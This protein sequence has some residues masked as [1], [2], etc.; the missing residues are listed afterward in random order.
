[1]GNDMTVSGAQLWHNI[2]T[3]M[4]Q[5]IM[6]DVT[7]TSHAWKSVK[8][9]DATISLKT[10]WKRTFQWEQDGNNE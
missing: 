8:D 9:N 5:T 4:E 3:K 6:T 7:T 10:N 2:V 1:M